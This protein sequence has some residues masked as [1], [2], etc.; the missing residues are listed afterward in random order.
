MQPAYPHTA[1]HALL[2]IDVLCNEH[3]QQVGILRVVNVNDHA[4]VFYAQ[5]YV[6]NISE[7]GEIFSCTVL[8][9]CSVNTCRH[10]H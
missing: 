9:A 7:V 2:P 5:P 1:T 8:C 3:R 10:D 6:M 4:P